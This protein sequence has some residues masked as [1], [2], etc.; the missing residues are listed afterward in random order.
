MECPYLLSRLIVITHVYK[1]QD[2]EECLCYTYQRTMQELFQDLIIVS[3][4]KLHW[5][6]W[7]M[8]HL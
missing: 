2:E 3:H 7:H 5:C 1:L 8:F 6:P 4:V